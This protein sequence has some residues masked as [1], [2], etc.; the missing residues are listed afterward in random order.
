MNDDIE[1][2]LEQIEAMFAQTA[3]EMATDGD[4][5]TFIGTSPSTLY[6]SDR[7]ERVVGHL[8]S[9]Q[10]VE[11]WGEGENSF[12]T[13]PPNAVIAFLGDGDE[14][15]EDA[16][17]VLQDPVLDGDKLAGIVSIGDLVRAVIADQKFVIEQLAHYIQ[18]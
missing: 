17:V 5:V 1:K 8:T 16:I 10:F 15:P 13:D 9:R 12:A 4:K 11:L 14:T 6:F 2:Q 18:G 7:P 3:R